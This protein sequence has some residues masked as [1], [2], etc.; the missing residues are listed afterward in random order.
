[1]LDLCDAHEIRV[2]WSLGAGSFTDTRLDAEKGWVYGE[3][4]L[5]ELIA[6]PESRSRQLLYRY[7]DE[8]VARYR[9]RK[10]VLMWEISNEVTLQADIG[11]GNRIYNGERMPTLREVA[12]FFDDVAKRIKSV[13]PLRLVTSGGS[14]MRESQWHLHLGQGWKRDTYE[15]QFK[16]FELLYA[17]SAV[18]VIDIHSYPNG[19][20]GYLIAD[21]EGKEAWLNNKG[22]AAISSRLHK[23]LMIG[24]LGLQPSPKTNEEIW[25]STPN[26]F[27]SYANKDAARPWVEKTLNDVVEARVPLT[28]WWCYQS[29]RSDDANNGQRLDVSRE[30]NPELVACVAEANRHLQAALQAPPTTTSPRFRVIAFYTGKSDRAHISFVGEANRWFGR[31]AAEHGF[32]Y[33]STTN[34]ENLN[35][36]FLAKYNVVVFLD[37]RPESPAQREAFQSY[38]RN[39]GGWIGFHFAGF[40]LTPSQFPQNWDWYHNEFLGAG[41]YAG[42]TWKPTAAVLRVEDLEHPV[43]KGLPA[44]FKASPNEWYKWTSDLRTNRDIKIL[45]SID[46]ASFPL[47]TGPKPREIWHSGYYPVVWSNLKHRMV[48]FNMGHNDIDYDK[49]TYQEL[50][51]TFGNEAQDRLVL[52]ALEWLGTGE[53]ALGP[54]LRK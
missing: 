10:A 6:Q 38:I 37:T 14:N 3:E 33:D 24:E 18:D 32:A 45:A 26:Y 39:G 52:N 44:T 54:E 51:S 7:I 15:E 13:D 31:M 46:P 40:A 2:V 20:P 30:R 23:P 43:T 21:A 19:K 48:Y 27:E 12:G 11:D 8:T 42:N 22:Y 49:K 36:E 17:N 5:R 28:Y 53:R 4:Q 50:S 35:L 41:S 47:G 1:M 34:W 16:C 25:R 29:D 9:H